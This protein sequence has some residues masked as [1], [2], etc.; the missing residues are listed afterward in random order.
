MANKLN[1]NVQ[2]GKP[3]EDDVKHLNVLILQEEGWWVAQCLEYDIVAQAKTKELAQSEF[4]NVFCGRIEIAQELGIDPFED[5]PPPPSY[6]RRLAFVAQQSQKEMR[7][8]Q[9]CPIPSYSNLKLDF[10][11]GNV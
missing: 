9:T 4:L 6:Y 7:T 3:K 5:V 1:K 2:A 11:Y 8:P 10:I